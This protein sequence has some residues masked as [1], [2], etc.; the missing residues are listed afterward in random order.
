MAPLA[1]FWWDGTHLV[2]LFD[3]GGDIQQHGYAFSLIFLESLI[4]SF[5]SLQINI[6]DGWFFL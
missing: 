3:E 5:L 1:T 2:E 6:D 4:Y